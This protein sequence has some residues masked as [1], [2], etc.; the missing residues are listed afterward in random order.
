[1][2]RISWGWSYEALAAIA[3]QA[4]ATVC[5]SCCWCLLLLETAWPESLIGRSHTETGVLAASQVVE[6]K[7]VLL[8]V[9]AYEGLGTKAGSLPEVKPKS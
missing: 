3:A 6:L 2:L 8:N 1:M 5:L 4:V 7:A 9:T